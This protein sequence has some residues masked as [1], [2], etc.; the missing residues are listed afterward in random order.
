MQG[1]FITIEGCEGVGKSTQLKFLREYFDNIGVDAV[2]TREPGGTEI[3]EKIREVILDAN[4]KE[5]TPTTELLLYA[6]ARRQHTEE[7]IIPA[8]KSGKVV[9]CDR[10]ADSTTA[11]QGYA[12]DLDKATVRAL[13]EIAMAGVKIDVT[14]FL[15]LP[16]EKGFARKG[17][18]DSKDRL[19]SEQLSFHDKVY[20]GYCAIADA[21][22][23]RVKRI[24]ASKTAEEVFESIK[25]VLK[26]IGIGK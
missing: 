17:G 12:R 11:Y 16:P 19:E 22:K 10:Y 21:E 14:L 5:M 25:E 26:N 7:L 23:D 6:A 15:D 9:V 20:E 13:N 1:K 2:F 8:V 4:N 18:A 3:A 24:D